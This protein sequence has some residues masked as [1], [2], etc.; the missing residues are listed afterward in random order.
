ML[1]AERY[2]LFVL[3]SE[4]RWV[5]RLVNGKVFD[6][7]TM[8]SEKR[9]QGQEQ[10]KAMRWSDPIPNLGLDAPTREFAA[11]R[12]GRCEVHVAIPASSLLSSNAK[13]YWQQ[14][15]NDLQM[16]FTLPKALEFHG[17]TEVPPILH[18]AAKDAHESM[19]FI[20]DALRGPLLRRNTTSEAAG[21]NQ[22]V[23]EMN[24]SVPR[25]LLDE[26][27]DV[28]KSAQFPDDL[29]TWDYI[30][31]LFEVL[32]DKLLRFKNK[33]RT[34][35]I[36]QANRASLI[37]AIKEC[38]KTQLV[39]LARAR[40]VWIDDLSAIAARGSKASLLLP[41]TRSK[42]HWLSVFAKESLP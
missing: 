15:K 9:A 7:K 36:I 25:N 34:K 23:S 26:T 24:Q 38:S 3:T 8:K 13:E 41:K 12:M 29:L 28:A 18:D 42:E 11:Y 2:S 22:E 14:C 40:E 17:G 1:N 30:A 35:E 16:I 19:I 31:T 5:S 37:E 10:T 32:E 39:T 6:I 33:A 21:P 4:Q 27:T 20:R